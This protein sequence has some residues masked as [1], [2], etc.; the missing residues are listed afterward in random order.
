[1]VANGYLRRRRPVG[2]PSKM[3]FVI[4]GRRP[5][6]TPSGKQAIMIV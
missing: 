5:R 1:V 3:L 6:L 4:L 2:K